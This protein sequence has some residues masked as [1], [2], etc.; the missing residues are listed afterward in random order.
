MGLEDIEKTETPEDAMKET[1]GMGF[2]FADM[3]ARN[4]DLMPKIRFTTDPEEAEESC[5]FY[6]GPKDTDG[7]ENTGGV[8]E[9]DESAGIPRFT[10]DADG[11]AD[12]TGIS[13]FQNDVFVDTE[14][15][16]ALAR[17][18]ERRQAE[19]GGDQGKYVGPS[20][21]SID[22]KL[23]EATKSLTRAQIDL[24]AAIERG[25]GVMS[26]QSVV[27]SARKVVDALLRQHEEAVRFRGVE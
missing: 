15:V 4:A 22:F 14:S 24:Q 12:M 10:R 23:E 9:A 8:P 7:G 26:A 13:R 17:E 6:V 3:E 2:S 25:S 21:E 1:L 16:I 11:P 19:S 5:V 18:E 27:E 20:L